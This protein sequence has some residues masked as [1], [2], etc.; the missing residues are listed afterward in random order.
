MAIVETGPL[1]MATAS[2]GG[3]YTGVAATILVGDSAPLPW[4]ALASGSALLDLTT[5]TNPLVLVAGVY[6]IAVCIAG[7]GSSETV[8]LLGMEITGGSSVDSVSTTQHLAAG[9]AVVV[10]VNNTGA[11]PSGTY[12]IQAAT[13]VLLG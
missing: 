10:T 9:D 2:S 11:L 3:G 12:N 1:T 5:P 13:V 8:S 4:S 7:L 6:A